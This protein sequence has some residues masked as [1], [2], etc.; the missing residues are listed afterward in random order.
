M[1]ARAGLDHQ[2]D[3]DPVGTPVKSIDGI[4][5]A[6]LAPTTI[7]AIARVK[8]AASD[9]RPAPIYP[10]TAGAAPSRT[11]QG[12]G[13]HDGGVPMSGLASF[14]LKRENRFPPASR[15]VR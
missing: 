3:I 8:A 11:P 2:A 6:G 4:V 14:S 7:S 9:A 12:D 1:S 5:H 10:T 15:P 13:L